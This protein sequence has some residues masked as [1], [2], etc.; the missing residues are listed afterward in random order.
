MKQSADKMIRLAAGAAAG[1]LSLVYG[2]F[3]KGLQPEGFLAEG[4]I[5]FALAA[6]LAA[7]WVFLAHRAGNLVGAQAWKKRL[8]ALATA[9]ALGLVYAVLLWSPVPPAERPVYYLGCLGLFCLG[10]LFLAEAGQAAKG[11]WRAAFGGALSLLLV[12]ALQLPL[13]INKEF[14]LSPKDVTM[15]FTAYREWED[16]AP[17]RV[18]QVQAYEIDLDMAALEGKGFG[19]ENGALVAEENGATFSFTAGTGLYSHVIFEEIPAG[20]GVE[21]AGGDETVAAGFTGAESAPY[22]LSLYVAH[23]A[24]NLWLTLL[25]VVPIACVLGFTAMYAPAL[26]AWGRR[27]RKGTMTKGGA[28]LCYAVSAMPP[29]AFLCYYLNNNFEFLMVSQVL[30]VM[31]GLALVSLPLHALLSRLFKSPMSAILSMA[32]FW[33]AFFTY[34]LVY[35]PLPPLCQG[36]NPLDFLVIHLAVLGCLM[37]FIGTVA[38]L[39][40]ASRT[41]KIPALF[42]AVIILMNVCQVGWQTYKG[43]QVMSRDV[44]DDYVVDA[45]MPSPNIYWFHLDGML[46]FTAVEEMYGDAQEEFKTGL[47]DRGFQVNEDAWI[48]ASHHTY[49]ALLEMMA[50]DYYDNVLAPLV[51]EDDIHDYDSFIKL[52]RTFE[53][54]IPNL[55]FWEAARKNEFIPAF[56][57][58][59]YVSNAIVFRGVPTFDICDVLF[60]EDV[61][62]EV[63]RVENEGGKGDVFYAFVQS[64]NFADILLSTTPLVAVQGAVEDFFTW[65]YDSFNPASELHYPEEAAREV[66]GDKYKEVAVNM[67]RGLGDVLEEPE[68]KLVI[69]Q[70]LIAHY[71]YEHSADGEWVRKNNGAAVPDY[72]PQHQY[73]VKVTMGMVDMVLEADPDAIIVLQG[74]HGLHGTGRER[75]AEAGITDIDDIRLAYNSVISAVYIPEKWGGLDEPLDPLNITRLLVNRYVGENYDM[76]PADQPNQRKYQDSRYQ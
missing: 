14:G 32:A 51:K 67:V 1:F 17:L 49:A 66:V 9:L 11:G 76:L 35:N 7:G 58:K 56:E 52:R 20:W 44:K 72:Y 23:P 31:A 42:L 36:L 26:V 64:E 74:D 18:T 2:R 57:R 37:L 45:T 61:E 54:T 6:L 43:T 27:K 13:T 16:A 12:L 60:L 8:P 70:N 34:A 50:P 41:Y 47:A 53:E 38:C 46:S 69:I 40:N 22:S 59:G 15:T 33:I 10:V 24:G 63:A 73:A 19:Y 28:A 4:A 62:P 71:P 65:W 55:H 75:L 25:L 5:L 3:I 30:L 29:V 39:L 21:L 48:E 68:P